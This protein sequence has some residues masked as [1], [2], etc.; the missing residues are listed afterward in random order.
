MKIKAENLSPLSL[1]STRNIDS[2]F[3][4]I[5]RADSRTRRFWPLHLKSKIYEVEELK[6]GDSTR[7]YNSS[8][9]SGATDMGM[10]FGYLRISIPGPAH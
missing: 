8:R 7:V 1:A 5:G 2:T 4:P 9:V 6:F 10:P 3:T